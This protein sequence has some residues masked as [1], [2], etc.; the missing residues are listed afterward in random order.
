MTG[1]E[2]HGVEIDNSEG[3]MAK[4]D[5][6]LDNGCMAA[7]RRYNQT[8]RN[9]N[10]EMFEDGDN[11]DWDILKKEFTLEKIWTNRSRSDIAKNFAIVLLFG[12][13]PTLSDVVTDGLSVNSFLSSTVYTKHITDL[14]LMNMTNTH[15]CKHLSNV[16]NPFDPEG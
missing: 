10:R 16:S 15:D 9:R 3:E 13:I 4:P 12:L 1:N 7:I 2:I 11:L 6:N 5:E 8:N 14:S